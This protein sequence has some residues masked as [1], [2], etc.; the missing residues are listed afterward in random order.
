MRNILLSFVLLF[1][2]ISSAFAQKLTVESFKLAGSDLTAQTQPRKDLNNRNC[3][4]IKVG[5][6]LQ[7]VQFE[8]SI[9]G[10]VE[11]KTGEYWVYMPQ[12]NRQL[13]VKHANYAPVMVTFA[14]YGVEK[15]ESNRTY[16][17]II[18]ASGSTQV[19]QKQR[20]TIRYSPSSATVLVDNKM[21]KGTNGVAQTTLPVG[22]HSFVVAC[23]GYE[24]EEGTV[25]LKASAPSNIQIT[26]TK[27]AVA[28]QQNIVSQP[29]VA[30]Q[31]VVQA[32]IAHSDNITIPVKDGISIDM[33][34]VE[35]GTFTMGATPEMKNPNDDEKPTHRVTLTNDYYM[36]KY[37]VTQ[38]LWK[39]VMGNNPS[40]FKG[41]NLPV[42]N[43]SWYD[44][45]EFISKLNR[46]TGKTF[47]LPTEAEWEYAARGGNKS[48]GYQYSGS[49]NLSDVA[50]YKDN[51]GSKTHAV[52]TKQP[53][54][55]GIYDMSGNVYEWCQ[56]RYG[57][58]SSS[59]QVNPIGADIEPSNRVIRGGSWDYYARICRSSDRGINVPDNRSRWADQG[60]RLVLS[61]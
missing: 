29:A 20:L 46:I 26:L 48:R 47:R 16:E 11:N 44:C 40:K 13:K 42:E 10:N 52:G 2:A 36:G 5:I 57:A 38:A 30:Q 45:Q 14:D 15:L 59:S 23:E 41:D 34:R 50:W 17:L 49:N 3:A 22:Q 8:G 43:V 32:P 39:A 61:E 58:Y 4:L 54:E 51:G 6:G 19:A 31:H 27:E 53:N 7:G 18:T 21:V 25:K 56:D 60:L 33:V 24:S 55:L 9:M 35:A 12:G 1:A 37:E 28:I